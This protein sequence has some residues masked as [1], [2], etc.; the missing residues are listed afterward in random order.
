[1]T[2]TE[3]GHYLRASC[4]Q[5]HGRGRH[6]WRGEWVVYCEACDPTLP[7]QPLTVIEREGR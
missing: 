7:D 4:P 6:L 5:C 3:S 2:V 1:M